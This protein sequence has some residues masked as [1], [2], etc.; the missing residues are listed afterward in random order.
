MAEKR[1]HY[2]DMA[3]AANNGVTNK[4]EIVKM[5]LSLTKKIELSLISIQR[6]FTEVKQK[7][8]H[9]SY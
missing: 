7:E 3:F 5:D 8:S 2:I 6:I 4:K 9:S 1:E